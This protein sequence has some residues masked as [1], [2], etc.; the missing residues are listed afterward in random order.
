MY[1]PPTSARDFGSIE[2]RRCA[3]VS[4]TCSDYQ[5]LI[6]LVGAGNIHVL[7]IDSETSFVHSHSLLDT[8]HNP[9]NTNNFRAGLIE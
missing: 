9:S 5:Q 8:L 4:M 7:E 3:V 6:Y 2:R 1:D